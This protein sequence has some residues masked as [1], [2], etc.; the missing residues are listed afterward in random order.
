MKLHCQ[1]SE[2]ASAFQ[3]VNGVVPART[4]KDILKN[5]HLIAT[6]DGCT[7]VGTDQEVG[8]RVDV[9]GI[10]VEEPGETLLPASRVISVLRELTEPVVDLE[11]TEEG[12]LI[13]SGHS[14]FQLAAGDPAEFPPVSSFDDQPHYVLQG[15]HLRE[16]IRRTLFATD[17]EST[18]Y[19]LGG[20][21]VEPG[22]GKLTLAATDSRRLAVM[23][24]ACTAEGVDQP[25]N[26]Q[27]VIPSKAMTLIERSI[28]EHD[29]PV[30]LALHANDVLIRCGRST[31]YA[32]LVEGRFPRYSDV[33][34][35]ESTYLVDLVVGPFYSAVRQSQ[36]VTSDESRGVDF[37]FAD[38]TLTLTSRAADVGQARI[39]LPI[40]WD[41]DPL[42]ITFDPRFV[43]E[44]LR[45]LPAEAA[46][47][48]HL[49][50]ESS[51]A[52]FRTDDGYAYVVMPLA[53]D[54]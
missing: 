7:L 5:V 41:H 4:P 8:I 2:L 39:E 37:T 24:A 31:I 52:V 9:G 28:A 53:R 38:G 44:F 30:Q 10:E 22:D 34:P 43:A 25:E 14:E 32:R 45:V 27:P 15:D 26:P 18:R 48:L 50:D 12:V 33:I 3:I 19:A 13:R 21:L 35:A 40:A 17:T 1:R 29:S 49:I 16:A 11:L 47:Q 46:V 42:T 36:I 23:P 20:V 51:A 6:A 54:H